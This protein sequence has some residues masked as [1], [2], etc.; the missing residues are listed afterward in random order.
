MLR[1][2]LA[3]LSQPEPAPPWKAYGAFQTMIIAFMMVL[4][5]AAVGVIILGGLPYTEYLSWIIGGV[6]TLGFIWLTR[7]SPEDRAALRL[8]AFPNSSLL[9]ITFFCFGIA[10]ALDVLRR[11][12][13]V[14]ELQIFSATPIEWVLVVLLMVIIQ[15]LATEIVFRGVMYPALR[16]T[17]GVWTGIV[18]CTLAQS[19]FH[20]ITYTPAQ[21]DPNTL[22]VTFALPYFESFIL[23]LIRAYTGSTRAAIVGHMAFGLFA[24]IKLFSLGSAVGS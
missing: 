14:P 8:G 21:F 1:S 19:I 2:F 24:V 23:T 4:I 10:L 15:P 17:F 16:V 22:W 18:A 12:Q 20:F 11:Y 5:G 13:P 9:L 7:R 3:R 6:L